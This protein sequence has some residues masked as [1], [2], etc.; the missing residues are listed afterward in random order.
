[1][2]KLLLALAMILFAGSAYAEQPDWFYQAIKQDNPNEL[3]YYAES[4][5]CPITEDEVKGIVEGVLI[6]SRV[7]PL[8][9]DAIFSATLFLYINIKCIKLE[10][11]NPIFDIQADFGQYKTMPATLYLGALGYTGIGD[12]DYLTLEVKNAVERAMT[13][14]IKANFDL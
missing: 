7:K 6:R 3:A 14:Y 11:N 12:K 9:G 1:M 10:S 2:K 8:G 13:A 5:D 4:H